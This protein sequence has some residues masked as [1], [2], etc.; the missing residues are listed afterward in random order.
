MRTT[1]TKMVIVALVGSAAFIGCRTATSATTTTST[2]ATPT[3]DPA[4]SALLT[5]YERSLDD[6]NVVGTLPLYQSRWLL[7]TPHGSTIEANDASR[8]PTVEKEQAWYRRLGM[9]SVRILG[10]QQTQMGDGHHWVVH[11]RWGV[12]FE[13]TGPRV[14]EL[15]FTYV[16]ER[17][18]GG[19][20][21]VGVIVEA[22]VPKEFER[23][24]GAP[25]PT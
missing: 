5:E 16:I 1:L 2:E 19:A 13:R 17:V 15:P 7:A 3:I 14:L 20:R 8:V 24:L 12:T 9:S 23:H 6:T 22:N 25:L 11:V 18:P 4:V 10:V 21:F